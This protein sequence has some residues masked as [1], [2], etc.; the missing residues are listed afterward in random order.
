[1]LCASLSAS[2]YDFEV[3][4]IYYTKLSDGF[5]VKVSNKSNN[6]YAQSTYSG[7]VVIPEDV[8]YDG[9]SYKVTSI[10][11]FAFYK[12]K[13]TS[14]QLP[15]GIVSI[16]KCSFA[17]STSMTSCALPS[18]VT[19]IGDAAFS[20]CVSLQKINIPKGVSVLNLETF[21]S[22]NSIT[23]VR[24]PNTVTRI[25]YASTTWASSGSGAL[26][27]SSTFPCFA[28]CKSLKTVIIEDGDRPISFIDATPGFTPPTGVLYANEI[29]YGCPVTSVYIGRSLENSPDKG[30]F[31]NF[32]TLTSVEIGSLVKSIQ[33]N[34]FKG[35]KKNQHNKYS[36][37]CHQNREL[38][39]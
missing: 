3:D 37:K 8:T 26:N 30:L 25:F 28:N 23:E 12:S 19:S 2:A 20:R 4:G 29:F 11:Q 1:M 24:I 17:G 5:S 33:N 7:D 39:I 16:G 36:F 6:S 35:C 18:T 13:V 32:S 14:V 9:L 10:G 34:A 21:Y 22:C 15:D 27:A 38:V 31:Q